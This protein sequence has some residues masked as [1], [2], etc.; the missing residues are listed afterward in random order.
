[1]RQVFGDFSMQCHPHAEYSGSISAF[2][3]AASESPI[4]TV[5]NGP[6]PADCGTGRLR[7]RLRGVDVSA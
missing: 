1:M 7:A 6:S 5:R 4:S 3:F 2:D